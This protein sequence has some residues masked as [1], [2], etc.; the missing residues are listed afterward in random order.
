MLAFVLK[1]WYLARRRY[2]LSK[3]DRV[4]KAST[5]AA[6]RFRGNESHK[7]RK[8]WGWFV[9]DCAKQKINLRYE[10]KEVEAKLTRY[11]WA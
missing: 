7:E 11:R 10:L 8:A 2:L 6:N 3:L 4:S 5:E 1:H 9:Q